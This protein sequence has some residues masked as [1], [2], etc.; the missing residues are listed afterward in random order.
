MGIFELGF[1][2][3]VHSCGTGVSGVVL[4]G[5]DQMEIFNLQPLNIKILIQ[6]LISSI[7][8]CFGDYSNK[9]LEILMCINSILILKILINLAFTSF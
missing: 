1:R 9:S 6:S 8:D 2:D 4:R 7:F 5:R 3:E